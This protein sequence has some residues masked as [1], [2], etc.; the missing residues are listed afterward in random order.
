MPA[1]VCCPFTACAASISARKGVQ[2][3]C[4]RLTG[5]VENNSCS[6]SSSKHMLD[7]GVTCSVVLYALLPCCSTCCRACLVWCSVQCEKRIDIII[8]IQM[9][10]AQSFEPMLHFSHHQ[11]RSWLKAP[12]VL[13]AMLISGCAGVPDNT[14]TSLL[15]LKVKIFGGSHITLKAEPLTQNRYN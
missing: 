11:S 6:S 14:V 7:K 8:L 5:L 10:Q 12:V 13:H 3:S 1:H 15:H 2:E 9:M 4:E